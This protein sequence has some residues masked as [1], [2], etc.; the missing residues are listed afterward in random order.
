MPHVNGLELLR[1]MKRAGRKEKVIIM[2]G[3]S[4][5]QK[6][7]KKEIQPVVTH[8]DK[9]FQMDTMLEAVSTAFTSRHKN[10]VP[11]ILPRMYCCL[12][13]GRERN[14]TRLPS[15]WSLV[16]IF[17]DSRMTIRNIPTAM[18]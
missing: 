9:P 14:S 8:L 10:Q 17:M 16:K 4:L 5:N 3:N 2:S 6:D 12:K 13:T 7:F 1:R 11:A 18:T 15:P